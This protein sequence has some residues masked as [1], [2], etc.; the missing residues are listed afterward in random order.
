MMRPAAM[1]VAVDTTRVK[2][3]DR[4]RTGYAVLSSFLPT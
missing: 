1:N 4:K 2:L 3:A